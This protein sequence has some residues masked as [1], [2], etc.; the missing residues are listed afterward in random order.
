MP[1]VVMWLISSH[2]CDTEIILLTY[3]ETAL[4]VLLILRHSKLP[5]SSAALC[6]LCTNNINKHPFLKNKCTLP[7]PQVNNY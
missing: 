7:P 1:T 4:P 3:D 5:R 6:L 2:V